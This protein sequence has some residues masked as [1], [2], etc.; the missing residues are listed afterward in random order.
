MLWI[1][2]LPVAAVLGL[3]MSLLDQFGYVDPEFYTGYGLSFERMWH[4]F[5]L[6]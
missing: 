1:A 6:T 3:H 5:G 2:L 4:A